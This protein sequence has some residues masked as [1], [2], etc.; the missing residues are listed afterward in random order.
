MRYLG[1]IIFIA[2]IALLVFGA[3]AFKDSPFYQTYRNKAENLIQYIKR[4]SQ[5]KKHNIKMDYD[6][7][8]PKEEWMTGKKEVI[9]PRKPPMSLLVAKTKLENFFPDQFVKTLNQDDWDYIFNLIYEPISDKQGD[10]TV[11]R[12]LT[13]AEIEQELVYQ[14][15]FP[16]SYF[17]DQH[18]DYFWKIVLK[19][20]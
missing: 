3:I 20:G 1:T 2:V 4:W 19:N 16:F 9:H 6:I 8:V 10:F 17:R 5:V 14:Y 13:K 15:K 18:W 7:P 11:K 12:Y